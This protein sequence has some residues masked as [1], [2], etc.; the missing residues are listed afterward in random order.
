MIDF[1]VFLEYGLRMI[2]VHKKIILPSGEESCSCYRGADCTAKYKHPIFKQFS[3]SPIPS[4]TAETIK[5]IKNATCNFAVCAGPV[6]N[7]DPPLQLVIVDIDLPAIRNNDPLIPLLPPTLTASTPSG[8]LHMF[9]F[10]PQAEKVYNIATG[11]IDVRAS[12]NAYVVCNPSPGY[13][14][15]NSTLSLPTIT[16][17]PTM[18]TIPK[19]QQNASQTPHSANSFNF[20]SDGLIPIGERDSYV[21]SKLRQAAAN[22]YTLSELLSLS[23]SIYNALEQTPRNQFPLSA[24]REKA[25]YVNY[26]YSDPDAQAF[27]EEVNRVFPASSD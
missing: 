20:T 8:G 24:I 6:P 4:N 3:Q 17:L 23:D 14:F 13:T 27:R 22:G 7:T 19:S 2:P 18:P 26:N 16:T 25:Y 21:F 10:I 15:L 11:Y 9:Y 12:S 5:Q 1:T